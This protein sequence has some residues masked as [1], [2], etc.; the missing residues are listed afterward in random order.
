MDALSTSRDQGA[1]PV[2]RRGR[3]ARLHDGRARAGVLPDRRAVLLRAPRPRTRRAARCSA[4]S[5]R[6]ATSSTSTTSARSPSGSSPACSRPSASCSK[7]G[8]P[9]KTRHNEVAPGAVRARADLREL[10]R[11]LRPP[12]ADDA[13]DAERRPPL[14]ARLPAAREA[15]RRRQRLGQAQQLV[16]GHRHGPQPARARARRRDENAQFLFFCAAV[17]QA[18][19]KHQA[20]LRASRRERR[21]GPPPRRQRGA[22]GDHLDLPRR[23]AREG[24]YETIATGK[25]RR[26]EEG[27]PGPGHAGAAARCRC[28][29]ATA[30]APR[31]S[32][33]PATSSS[34]ARWARAC[35]SASPN[36]VLNTIVAEAID[37]AGRAAREALKT[38]RA[39]SR[40]RR[41][42]RR[43]AT[44]GGATSE[45]VFD[46]DGYSDAWHA[47]G[48]EARPD[49]PA[50]DARR[51]AVLRRQADGRRVREVQGAHR[52]RAR[53]ALRGLRRAVRGRSSTSRARPR[54]RSR[55]R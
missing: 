12:A 50:H 6:R 13:G 51:A 23:R 26:V 53:G 47:G 10:E 28:T 17:I 8:V 40:T 21:P 9:V 54:R 4:P 39:T 31:R 3:P 30:T 18:V 34:S 41:S 1:A 16:D 5:R 46:G 32:P 49:E 37:D 7:L 45:I 42:R 52:A 19:N 38:A 48:R 29:A 15:V 22:A 27:P 14:R 36:T 33:S 55:A 35:R 25:G 44:L 11:R 43:Q 20:L 2:R 24:V